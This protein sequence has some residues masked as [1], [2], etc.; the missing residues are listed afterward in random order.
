M[1]TRKERRTGMNWPAHEEGKQSSEEDADTRCVCDTSE[2]RREVPESV[3][4][5][6]LQ[7]S[8]IVQEAGG[9][10]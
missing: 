6:G 7:R 9:G 5:C 1:S 3:R 10:E 4:L 8:W 2:G